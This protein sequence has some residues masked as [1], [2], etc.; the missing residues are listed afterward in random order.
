MTAL[1]SRG[2]PRVRRWL[3]L[4][5]DARRRRQEGRALIEGAHLLGA[6]LDAGGRPDSVIVSA[7]A[8]RVSS[9]CACW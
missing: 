5:R 7:A 3:G 1:S 8:L 9:S 2:N 6:Y 4:V